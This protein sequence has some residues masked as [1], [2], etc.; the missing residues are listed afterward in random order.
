[1]RVVPLTPDGTD[2]IGGAAAIG[3]R[4]QEYELPTLAFVIDSLSKR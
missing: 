3:T 2:F 1:M 4:R